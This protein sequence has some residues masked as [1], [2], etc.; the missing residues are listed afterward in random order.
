MLQYHLATFLPNHNFLIEARKQFYSDTFLEHYY[1][2]TQVDTMDTRLKTLEAKIGN[3]ALLHRG[4]P[5][6]GFTRN[7]LD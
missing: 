2:N 3:K 4:L 6:T 5:A 1:T 7:N